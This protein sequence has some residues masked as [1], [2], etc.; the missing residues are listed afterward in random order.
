MKPRQDRK[1][2]MSEPSRRA[3]LASAA[4]AG[5]L[6]WTPVFRVTP[7]SAQATSAAPPNLPSSISI[8]QQAY[9]TWSG[10]IVLDNVC[11]CAPASASDVVIL[12]NWAHANGYRLRAKGMSHNW[13]PILLPAG[14]TGA[15]YVL[16]DTAHHLTSVSITTGSPA[17]ATA[18][19]GVFNDTATTA[20]A[21]AG[22][23]FCAIPAPGD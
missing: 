9:Q 19:A 6:A 10:A 2:T 16:L 15:G 12:A 7:A 3:F 17:T 5:A 1:P 11:T 8:Y 21:A 14:S 22:Y 20:L 13:S 4:A 18:Q 23:G